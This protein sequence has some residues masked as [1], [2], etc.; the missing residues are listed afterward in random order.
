[1][2]SVIRILCLAVTCLALTTAPVRAEVL[3]VNSILSAQKA[4][5][6][7]DGIIAMINDPANTVD[8]SSGDLVTLRDAGVSEA[9]ITALWARVPAPAPTAVRAVPDDP[10]LADLVRLINSEFPSR[11]SPSR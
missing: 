5:A 2:R 4:G 9:V 3:T 10:R 1:M 6:Q 7:T 8:V 11:S